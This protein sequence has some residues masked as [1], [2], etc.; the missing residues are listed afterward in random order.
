MATPRTGLSPAA[1][2]PPPEPRKLLAARLVGVGAIPLAVFCAVYLLAS[3]VLGLDTPQG[4]LWTLS[5]ALAGS[6]ASLFLLGSFAARIV[7]G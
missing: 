3:R 6:V 5:L 7:V 1:E 2:A 4:Q